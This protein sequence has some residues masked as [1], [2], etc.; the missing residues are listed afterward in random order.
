MEEIVLYRTYISKGTPHLQ[1]A[2]IYYAYFATNCSYK[3]K[4][5][6]IKENNLYTVHVFYMSVKHMHSPCQNN[7]EGPIS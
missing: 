4:G 3:G 6:Q 7:A 5:A 1:R 2:V